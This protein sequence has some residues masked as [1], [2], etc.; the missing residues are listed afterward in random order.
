M[1]QK[2]DSSAGPEHELHTAI[3]ALRMPHR[4]PAGVSAKNG[5]REIALRRLEHPV[6]RQSR[7]QAPLVPCPLPWQK[8]G[9]VSERHAFLCPCPPQKREIRQLNP[10]SLWDS[11]RPGN[12]YSPQAL[13]FPIALS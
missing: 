5:T 10:S 2:H 3:A 8:T 9:T 7:Q 12:G 6:L 4:L 13:P 11:P 1:L